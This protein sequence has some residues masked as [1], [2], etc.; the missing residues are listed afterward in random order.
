[1][2]NFDKN[3]TDGRRDGGNDRQKSGC[4]YRTLLQAGATKTAIAYLQ[5]PCSDFLGVRPASYTHHFTRGRKKLASV[6]PRDSYKTSNVRTFCFLK[7]TFIFGKSECASGVS[8]QCLV[9]PST[10][11]HRISTVHRFYL[12]GQIINTKLSSTR[13]KLSRH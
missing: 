5:M 10:G 8:V 2:S 13:G 11:R 4:L 3:L 9:K 1:M 12:Y 7:S 6:S